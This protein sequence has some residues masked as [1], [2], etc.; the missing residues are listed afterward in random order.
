M[1]LHPGSSTSWPTV[2]GAAAPVGDAVPSGPRTATV[3]GWSGNQRRRPEPPRRLTSDR[4]PISYEG[5]LLQGN[6]RC[7]CRAVHQRG[8]V[9]R[10]ATSSAVLAA[11][12]GR[13]RVQPPQPWRDRAHRGPLPARRPGHDPLVPDAK[14]YPEQRFDQQQPCSAAAMGRAR[15]TST[16]VRLVSRTSAS[17]RST[18]TIPVWHGSHTL[19]NILSHRRHAGTMGTPTSHLTS[20][21]GRSP[22]RPGAGPAARQSG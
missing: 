13:L 15:R 3:P 12:G 1:D 8:P 10:R 11:T 2:R 4:P 14:I 19:R 20:R 18:A 7:V 6:L 22:R 17:L 5:Y 9:E 21:P 16:A